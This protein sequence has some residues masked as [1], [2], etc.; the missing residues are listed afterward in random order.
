MAYD[1]FGGTAVLP[2]TGSSDP[3]EGVLN[4]AGLDGLVGCVRPDRTEDMRWNV[5]EREVALNRAGFDKANGPVSVFAAGVVTVD[6]EC[7]FVSDV[8]DGFVIPRWITL[9]KGHL[10]QRCGYLLTA[11]VS[12][13]RDG[14]P[15]ATI[16][17]SATG[18]W[19]CCGWLRCMTRWGG[20]WSSAQSAISAQ[21]NTVTHGKLS[22]FRIVYTQET[23]IVSSLA[24]GSLLLV[25]FVLV[26]L[27]SR[28]R[29]NSERKLL[30]FIS[31]LSGLSR[32]VCCMDSELYTVS[33][34][35]TMA[36]G[37]QPSGDR[38]GIRFSDVLATTWNA[39]KSFVM[40]KSPVVV[41]LDTSGIKDVLGFRA[42]KAKAEAARVLK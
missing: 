32:P 26:A 36:E 35:I 27:C 10:V 7:V 25:C 1:E 20:A 17:P 38:S 28:R 23:S 3:V 37:G 9:G 39:P 14:S 4:T 15:W 42:R 8:C 12:V 13:E 40:L 29:R 11:C 16:A 33:V 41:T 21:A 5:G 2:K 18:G 34:Y 19:Q 31:A 6:S 24:I 22:Y 30:S